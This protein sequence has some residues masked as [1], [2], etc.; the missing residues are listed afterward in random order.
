MAVV[1]PKGATQELTPLLPEV[2]HTQHFVTRD[3][4]LD[5]KRC[6]HLCHLVSHKAQS[7]AAAAVLITLYSVLIFTAAA[8]VAVTA[9]AAVAAA[10]TDLF[11]P[12][13]L[14]ASM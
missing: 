9:A 12:V 6:H 3:H 10:A 5:P 14:A 4:T 7:A 8:A 13:W 11:M 2:H 1:L